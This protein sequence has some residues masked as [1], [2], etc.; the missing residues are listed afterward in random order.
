M[1][2]SQRHWGEPQEGLVLVGR[3]EAGQQRS[4]W[5]FE[6]P[7]RSER[8]DGTALWL[9][10]SAP[11]RAR[12]VVVKIGLDQAGGAL[13][14]RE[15]E[16]RDGLTAS[17][18]VL[19]MLAA[20]E[21][22]DYGPS[23]LA[24]PV[25]EGGSVAD[26]VAAEGALSL[27]S[28]VSYALQ[29]L[30]ALSDT[31][32]VHRDL[33]PSNLLRVQDPTGGARLCVSDWG[34][35]VVFGSE[36]P[37]ELAPDSV[38]FAAP[39][40]LD[41]G[42]FADARDDLLSIGAILWWGC[43]GEAPGT[44]RSTRDMRAVL[45]ARE[46]LPA[47]GT[48]RAVPPSLSDFVAMVLR[49]RRDERTPGVTGNRDNLRWAQEQLER[50]LADVEAAERGGDQVIMTG[51]DAA[52][53]APSRP[54]A[55]RAL[56]PGLRRSAPSRELALTA[57]A[58]ATAAALA[59]PQAQLAPPRTEALP[60]AEA[61]TRRP[62]PTALARTSR[63]S[64]PPRLA[65]EPTPPASLTAPT[66]APRRQDHAA[67]APRPASG[68]RPAAI[69]LLLP[70]VAALFVVHVA[71]GL[72]VFDPS[73]VIVGQLTLLG[74]MGVAAGVAVFDLA[75][76]RRSELLPSAFTG[77]SPA[78]SRG[79]LA[80]R[81]LVAL[82]LGVIIAQG[83]AVALFK[84]ELDARRADARQQVLVAGQAGIGRSLSEVADHLAA[85]TAGYQKQDAILHNEASQLR[86]SVAAR[87][88]A[89]VAAASTTVPS[90]QGGVDTQAD[91]PEAVQVR[92][93]ERR[94]ADL[95]AQRSA[96]ADKHQGT[97][98]RLRAQ[99]VRLQRDLAAVK[100][101]PATTQK[102]DSRMLY[103]YL[104]DRP[105]AVLAFLALLVLALAF[106][107]LPASLTLARHRRLT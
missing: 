77:P 41:Q 79:V 2:E 62:E 66:E 49:S 80:L 91:G 60:R 29:I 30:R 100:A 22:S 71:L 70:A 97:V 90:L 93:D 9:A 28:L 74:A 101:A 7:L 61:P 53:A 4:T 58:E 64:A 13:V 23:W 16:L 12:Q 18:Y 37:L 14:R 69:P 81:G 20:S 68:R 87:R 84:P 1:S 5:V 86:E 19:P 102:S 44:S 39:Q 105:A 65:P 98:D 38:E 31:G 50:C 57:H 40:V 59:A 21:P 95:A 85:S 99:R 27:R 88:A 42:E 72:L 32:V 52:P 46:A 17:N 67:A 33:R 11:D 56:P 36:Q 34:R 54:P 75:L 25:A 47:L 83:L 96:L 26:R 104:A 107:L 35:S 43:T 6:R 48:L 103:D 45:R 10:D 15:I 24:T 3:P 89:E 82:I 51:A 92:R 78:A 63:R 94:L 76:A 106:E 55:A 73:S 8:A